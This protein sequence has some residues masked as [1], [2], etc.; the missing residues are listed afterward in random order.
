MTSSNVDNLTRLRI[1]ESAHAVI[2]ELGGL[3]VYELVVSGAAAGGRCLHQPEDAGDRDSLRA[4]LRLCLAGP[5]AEAMAI[6]DFGYGFRPVSS[7]D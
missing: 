3:R 6:A 5:E 7:S 2:A 1:H 4:A